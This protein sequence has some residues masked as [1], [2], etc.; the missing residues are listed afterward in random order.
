MREPHAAAQIRVC[1]LQ[2]CMAQPLTARTQWH[3]RNSE[4]A[5]RPE[6][7]HKRGRKNYK[8]SLAD[9]VRWGSLSLPQLIFLQRI[10]F[11]SRRQFLGGMGMSLL[12]KFEEYNKKNRKGITQ[13]SIIKSGSAVFSSDF[14]KRNELGKA[15]ET[16]SFFLSKTND[17]VLGIRFFTDNKGC[18][19]ITK[20]TTD[21]CCSAMALIRDYNGYLG[22]YKLI[23]SEKH[24]GYK[25]CIFES[26]QGG[27]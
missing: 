8:N 20:R 17:N 13:L 24:D 7:K 27:N 12:D 14:A 6:L 16:L 9:S 18:L 22:K 10:Q 23:N 15:F 11:G 26:V 1:S 21:A 3:R 4:G 5:A 19:K 25:D 2:P